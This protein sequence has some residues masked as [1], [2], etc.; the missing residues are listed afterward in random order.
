MRREKNNKGEIC[1]RKWVFPT[2]RFKRLE[3]SG[4][5]TKFVPRVPLITSP[6]IVSVRALNELVWT[7]VSVSRTMMG[8]AKWKQG[9]VLLVRM[10][11]NQRHR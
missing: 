1:T 9:T 11:I 3:L 6:T 8:T 7:E 10:R 5:G 4:A 2:C